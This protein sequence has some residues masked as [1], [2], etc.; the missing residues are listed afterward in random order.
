MNASTC[1]ERKECQSKG[2]WI[3]FREAQDSEGAGERTKNQAKRRSAAWLKPGTP[4]ERAVSQLLNLGPLGTGQQA[5]T[6]TS[7]SCPSMASHG[8]LWA[9]TI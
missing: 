4:R 5:L 1:S 8:P 2:R 9:T 6:D 7:P 3:G